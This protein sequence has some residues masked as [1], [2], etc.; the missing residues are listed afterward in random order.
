M[1]TRLTPSRRKHQ[2]RPHRESLRKRLPAKVARFIAARDSHRC[3][4]CG[5]TAEESGSHLH[6]DH[7][8]PRSAGGSDT[9]DNLVLACRACNCTRKAMTLT[10]WS[11]YVAATRNLHPATI[12]RRVRR[13]LAQPLP[14]AA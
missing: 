3:I 6:L 2:G 10:E 11:R 12:A 7:V 13:R 1:A 14:L 4:Y 9:A 5:A 8:V